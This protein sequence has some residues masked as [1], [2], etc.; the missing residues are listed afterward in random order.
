MPDGKPNILVLWGDDIGTWNL[1]FFNRG[2][3]GYTTP[4]IDSIATAII[5]CAA[6]APS[7]LQTN[8]DCLAVSARLRS[9]RA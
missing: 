4:N 5:E 2:M 3:M 1:S 7:A 9:G 8:R 6:A